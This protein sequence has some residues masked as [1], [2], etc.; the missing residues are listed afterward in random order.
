MAQI[1]LASKTRQR[2]M[3]NYVVSKLKQQQA[4]EVKDIITTT[5]Q[6]EPNDRLKAELLHRYTTSR[7]QR[8]RH[9][10]Q[11]PKWATGKFGDW[12]KTT[13]T[14]FFETSGP[15]DF[16][17]TS[18]PLFQA[19]PKAVSPQPPTS[20]TEF[21]RLFPCLP[22]RASPLRRTTTRPG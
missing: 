3:F 20:R 1:E 5:M 6:Q 12:L 17:R 9:L 8:V 13:R 14:I 11:M 2:T 7:E 19:R 22:Q 18:K 15:A 21:A 4:T 10:I 16:H